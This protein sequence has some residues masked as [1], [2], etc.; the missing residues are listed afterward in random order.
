MRV[1]TLFV[2][3]SAQFNPSHVAAWVT[4]YPLLIRLME[5]LVDD[6]AE[7]TYHWQR[8]RLLGSETA[9]TKAEALVLSVC[10]VITHV[11]PGWHRP[12]ARRNQRSARKSAKEALARATLE[13]DIAMR[14]DAAPRR[15]DRRLAARDLSN[16]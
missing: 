13:F 5:R 2:V 7:V 14:A 8:V 3:H 9:A 11:D 4:G 10:D 12:R 15:S 1:D 16:G 6:F